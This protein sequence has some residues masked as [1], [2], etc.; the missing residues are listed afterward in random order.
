[1]RILAL[2]VVALLSSCAGS[3]C[4]PS[5]ADA[6]PQ[7]RT[8]GEPCTDGFAC[9]SGLSCRSF[10]LSRPFV[11]EEC[12]PS[13]G[14]AGAC[15]SGTACLEGEG[16]STCHVTCAA[17]VDCTGRFGSS[18]FAVDAG[19]VHGICVVRACTSNSECTGGGACVKQEYCCPPGAPCAAPRDG[20]C[21]R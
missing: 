1:M 14:D 4:T 12:L 21:L 19:V 17:D 6:G 5:M 11:Q 8:Q 15:P 3:N 16:R 18:C 13:C 20:F 9:A 2:V 7:P 10:G